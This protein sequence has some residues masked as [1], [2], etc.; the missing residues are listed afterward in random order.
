MEK[1]TQIFTT[2]KYQKKIAYQFICLSII[3]LDLDQVK[4]IIQ[5]FL[6]ECKYAAKE[7]KDA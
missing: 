7:K 4:I 2:I 6:E 3:L 5:V 1:S